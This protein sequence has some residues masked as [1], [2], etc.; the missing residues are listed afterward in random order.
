M[1]GSQRSY[2]EHDYKDLSVKKTFRFRSHEL[3]DWLFGI[4]SKGTS[5]TKYT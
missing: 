3:G 1:H 5:S 4:D 2:G